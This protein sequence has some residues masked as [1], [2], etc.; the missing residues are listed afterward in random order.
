MKH[1]QKLIIFFRKIIDQFNMKKF[2]IYIYIF[3]N[4]QKETLSIFIQILM[5]LVPFVLLRIAEFRNINNVF[6]T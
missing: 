5:I 2:Q 1:G 3:Q 6:K 4:F